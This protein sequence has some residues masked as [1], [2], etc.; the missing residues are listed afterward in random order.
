MLIVA[1]K[2]FLCFGAN[3][4][5]FLQLFQHCHLSERFDNQ[6]HFYLINCH[7]PSINST[8]PFFF[9]VCKLVLA[10][11]FHFLPK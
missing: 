11:C 2:Y 9:I 7:F 8:I 5:Y 4:I 10:A 3:L 1:S 6:T